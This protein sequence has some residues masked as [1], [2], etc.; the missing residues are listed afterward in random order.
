MR[1][2]S[3]RR[4]FPRGLRSGSVES[5]P[6][7]KSATLLRLP[8]SSLSKGASCA[9]PSRS[10]S[11]HPAQFAVHGRQADI[12]PGLILSSSVGCSTPFV[13]SCAIK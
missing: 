6:A 12:V 3:I 4:R 11:W 5:M 2:Y 7:F 8:D 13:T 1:I 10:P 9:L